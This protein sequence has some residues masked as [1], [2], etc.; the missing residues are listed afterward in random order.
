MSSRIYCW[1]HGHN[2]GKWSGPDYEDIF[3]N[4][5]SLRF[6]EQCRASQ[7]RCVG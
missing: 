6:C 2:W 7:R 5:W 1:L 3:R 4:V